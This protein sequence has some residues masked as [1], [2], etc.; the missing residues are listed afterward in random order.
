MLIPVTIN[1]VYDW[2]MKG[3]RT[4]SDLR[5]ERMAER[6]RLQTAEIEE[7]LA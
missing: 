2:A 5:A 3:G 6:E 4:L 7:M 1:P